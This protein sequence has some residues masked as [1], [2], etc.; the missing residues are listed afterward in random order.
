[1]RFAFLT[2]PVL[3]VP[4]AAC[5]AFRGF[6]PVE[7][8]GA[9][10]A[11]MDP[12]CAALCATVVD[13]TGGA[14]TEAS[15]DA[16]LSACADRLA[17]E[18]AACGACLLAFASFDDPSAGLIVADTQCA[19]ATAQFCGGGSRCTM[20]AP[21]GGTCS[22]CEADV[23]ARQACAASFAPSELDCQ[24]TFPDPAGCADACPAH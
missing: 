15:V 7:A 21:E 12:R 11:S 6:A 13:A 1:M 18:T 23:N 9:G 17:V 24:I 4:L 2:L 14:C 19:P 22:Y 20:T 8:D 5:S 16:C 10:G 3:A